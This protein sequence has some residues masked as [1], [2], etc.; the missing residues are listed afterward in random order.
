MSKYF[1]KSQIRGE[2]Q[3]TGPASSEYTVSTVKVAFAIEFEGKHTSL[4]D[5]KRPPIFER[6]T[7]TSGAN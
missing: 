7:F 1:Q 5:Y 6:Y 4:I 3:N 2:K